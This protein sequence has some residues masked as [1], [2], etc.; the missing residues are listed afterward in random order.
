MGQVV[1]DL[2]REQGEHSGCFGDDGSAG[3][4]GDEVSEVK[5]NA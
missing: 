4:H 5:D 1:L 2:F 3:A